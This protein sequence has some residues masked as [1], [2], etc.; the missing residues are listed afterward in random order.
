MLPPAAPFARVGSSPE[1]PRLDA[2]L[3]LCIPAMATAQK[4]DFAHTANYALSG[5]N[6]EHKTSVSVSECKALCCARAWCTSFD[7]YKGESKC[8]LSKA[9]PSP[10]LSADSK[11][12]H[13]SVDRGQSECTSPGWKTLFRQ[14]LPFVQATSKFSGRY[15][16]RRRAAPCIRVQA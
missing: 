10:A 3:A 11:H 16:L 13:Y 8:D 2:L 14:S 7:Y 6:E 4:C 15:H 5:Y 12:D 1:M 9:N